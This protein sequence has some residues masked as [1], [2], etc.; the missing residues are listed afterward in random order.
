AHAVLGGVGSGQRAGR[1]RQGLHQ[2]IRHRDEIRVRPLDELRRSLPQRAQLPRQALRPDHRRQPVDRRRRREQ[3]V[4]QAQRLLRQ[5]EDLDGRLRP[6]DR[7]RLFAMAEE[8]AELLGAA[9]HG[10]RGGLDLSQGLVLATR[11]SIRVQ[12]QVRPRPGA[13]EDL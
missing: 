11:D 7:R 13:A 6:G 9:G 12:G 2:A 5:G 3:V 1:A 4:R 10:R 8:H